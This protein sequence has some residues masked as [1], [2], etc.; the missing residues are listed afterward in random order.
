MPAR[1]AAPASGVHFAL[2]TTRRGAR[3]TVEVPTAF[4]S[5][6]HETVRVLRP[7]RLRWNRLSVRSREDA[8]GEEAGR[9][10][11]LR[12]APAG[13]RRPIPGATK[14]TQMQQRKLGNSGL[15]VSA[16]GLGCMGLS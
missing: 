12:L 6:L 10:S 11:P 8:H 14:E 16:I 2:R 13:Q 7:N 1:L 3:E 5:P 15:E 9:F 4:M